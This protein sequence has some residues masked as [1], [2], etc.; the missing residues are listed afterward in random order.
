MLAT[1]SDFKVI[2]TLLKYVHM[3]IEFINRDH[4]RPQQLHVQTL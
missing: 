1:L 3:L 4:T 2:E